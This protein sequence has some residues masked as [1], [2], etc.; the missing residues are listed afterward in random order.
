[1]VGPVT[2]ERDVQDKAP[3]FTVPADE[4]AKLGLP[5]KGDGDGSVLHLRIWDA[6]SGEELWSGE[7][8]LRSGLEVYG[9]SRPTT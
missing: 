9:R 5:E 4:H 6:A 7:K 3:R 1:M 2:F 8:Q